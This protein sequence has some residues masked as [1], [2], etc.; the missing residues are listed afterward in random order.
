MQYVMVYTIPSLLLTTAMFKLKRIIVMG[1][2]SSPL[3]LVVNILSVT[4]S[5]I[6][7]IHNKLTKCD[8]YYVRSLR[9]HEHML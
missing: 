5:A 1:R 2:K 6:N 3:F 4:I 7:Y 8:E 9:M